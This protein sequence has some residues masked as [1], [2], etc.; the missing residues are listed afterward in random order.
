M[1]PCAC[2][3]ARSET[4]PALGSCRAI[5]LTGML[6]VYGR[7]MNKQLTVT[8]SSDRQ[9]ARIFIVFLRYHNL[10]CYSLYIGSEAAKALPELLLVVD[11]GLN[12][13]KSR[14]GRLCETR[15]STVFLHPSFGL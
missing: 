12:P 11:F 8:I 7:F 15:S 5:F 3:H 4:L 1:E 9:L 13:S 14:H 10:I 6:Y 2:G